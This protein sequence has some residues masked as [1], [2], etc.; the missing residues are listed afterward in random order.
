MGVSDVNSFLE[1]KYENLNVKV[2][3]WLKLKSIVK[4]PSTNTK[5]PPLQL[6]IN[7]L[8]ILVWLFVYN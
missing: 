7:F 6:S 4:N 2:Q 3:F 5:P 8:E 1:N